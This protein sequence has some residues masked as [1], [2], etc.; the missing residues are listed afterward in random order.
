MNIVKIVFL[1]LLAVLLYALM[2]QLRPE[3]AP[4]VALAG[5]GVILVQLIGVLLNVSST[6]ENLI[7][8]AG[9]E[10]E[11]VEILIKALAVCV[12]TQFASDVCYDNSFSSAAAAV[13]LAGRVGAIALA[14]PMIKAAAEIAIGLIN[15]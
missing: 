11:N 6:V 5:V 1:C 2:R 7:S 9:L 12:I 15:A 3:F 4:L 8:L 10:K 13:E 14:M